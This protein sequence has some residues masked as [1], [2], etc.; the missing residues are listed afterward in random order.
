M[1]K[2]YFLSDL[3]ESITELG[4]QP[5]RIIR[6][7][8]RQLDLLKN[9]W[10]T[11]LSEEAYSKTMGTLVND[12]CD[13]IIKNIVCLEDISS[14]VAEGLVN[15]IETIIEKVPAIFTV[16]RKEEQD[17]ICFV[18]RRFYVLQDP[19]EVTVYVKKWTK[20]EQ[21]K[22]ILNATMAQILEQWADGKGPLTLNFKAED[23]R[24][25]IRALFQNTDRRARALA[26]IN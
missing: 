5:L 15:I 8:L 19:V 13:E 21:L 7:C 23:I 25:L 22:M 14:A 24:H 3:S 26:A 16:G 10:Q 6:Q 17:S 11:I 1:F 20:L 9:V 2:K 12:F 4:T 18:K